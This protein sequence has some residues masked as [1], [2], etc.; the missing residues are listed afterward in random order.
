MATVK[1]KFKLLSSSN[2]E[3][4]LYIQIIHERQTKLI[5]TPYKLHVSEWSPYTGSF[6]PSADPSRLRTLLAIREALRRD[7]HRLQAI[8]TRIDDDNIGYSVNDIVEEYRIYLKRFSLST[9]MT[10]RI[11]TLTIT[12]KLRTAQNYRSTMR[13]FMTFLAGQ[14]TAGINADFMV[15]DMTA[16]VISDYEAFLQAKKLRPNTTSFY[17][18]VLRA[19]C[20][21]AA[22]HGAFI[23]EHP[24]R[25][26]YTGVDRTEKRALPLS[27]IRRLNAMNLSASPT[28]D[29]ARDMFMLSFLTRG[30]SFIDMAF[31]LK[32]DLKNGYLTYRRHKTGQLLTIRWT[33]EMQQIIDKYP[34]NP[35]DYLFPILLNPASDPV[36][37]YRNVSF[38]I[39]R[40]LKR[41]A[42]IAGLKGTFTLY[43]ARHSW[44]S[45]AWA[46]GIP[47]SIISQG[48]G[49]DSERTTRI[50]LSS[51]SSSAID[52]ANSKIIS[53]LY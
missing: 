15:D 25:H 13:S 17:M 53:A 16:D 48:M 30:M 14:P 36:Y 40:S 7:L 19:V 22:D 20:N 8:I 41:L 28:L 12:G 42:A 23:R 52:R 51:L 10:E 3:G 29:Y 1:A 5:S 34:P 43:S 47:V 39:N 24:F 21:Y 11:N 50:Y 32:T 33:D 6:C 37:T 35:T 31:L 38:K 4:R 18:R 44:A 45:I 49:H 46:K 2:D 9:I 26:V 27:A